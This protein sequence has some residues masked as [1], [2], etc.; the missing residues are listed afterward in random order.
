MHCCCCDSRHRDLCH[1]DDLCRR[2]GRR[3]DHGSC[4]GCCSGKVIGNGY[5]KHDQP[6]VKEEEA[7]KRE[8][9]EEALQDRTFWR[10]T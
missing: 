8:Q 10:L 5:E 9:E 1:H 2:G 7:E 3:G 4:R 6:L